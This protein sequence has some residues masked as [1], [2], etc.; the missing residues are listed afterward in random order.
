MRFSAANRAHPAAANLGGLAAH[1]VF[2][3]VVAAVTE[4]AWGAVRP[5]P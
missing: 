5:P 4:A 2:G 1:L 3:L